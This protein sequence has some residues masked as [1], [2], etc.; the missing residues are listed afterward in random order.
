MS[1]RIRPLVV[2]VAA[3]CVGLAGCSDDGGDD[4]SASNGDGNGSAGESVTVSV[5]DNFFDPESVSIATGG[6]VQWEWVGNEPHNVN[7]DDFSSELQSEGT[8]EHT[9][10]DE[11]TY[12]YVCTIHPGMEGTVEVSG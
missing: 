2:L 10:E 12:D 8:F 4:D 11:G 1:H 6:T 3:L 9:F 7:H 5:D